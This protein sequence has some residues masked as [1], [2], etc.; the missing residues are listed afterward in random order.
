MGSERCSRGA[1]RRRREPV[2][3]NSLA[4]AARCRLKCERGAWRALAIRVRL[5]WAVGALA[6]LLGGASCRIYRDDAGGSAAPAPEGSAVSDGAAEDIEAPPAASAGAPEQPPPA[7]ALSL[8]VLNRP[9]TELV[10][11]GPAPSDAPAG[12][13]AS[14]PPALALV[15]LGQGSGQACAELLARRA[16]RQA[17]EGTDPLRIVSTL[18]E[19]VA[20]WRWSGEHTALDATIKASDGAFGGVQSV[21]ALAF[22][23]RLLAAAWSRAAVLDGQNPR[24]LKALGTAPLQGPL[25]QPATSPGCDSAGAGLRGPAGVIFRTPDARYFAGLVDQQSPADA[26][27]VSVVTQYGVAVEAGPSGGVLALTDCATLPPGAL[28][29]EVY[30]RLPEGSAP[31]GQGERCQIHHAIVTAHGARVTG[32]GPLAWASASDHEWVTAHETAPLA[33]AV[34]APDAGAKPPGPVGA[35]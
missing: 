5:C 20:R 18:L 27:V 35:P 15:A 2:W 34:G 28:A 4:A 23:S 26:G 6:L 31:A 22:S 10:A 33:P 32:A 17:S 11:R 7:E 19:D 9:E 13:V 25:G 3:A 24:W 16:L 1:R 29:A 30:A 21:P 12:E 14:T 8:W